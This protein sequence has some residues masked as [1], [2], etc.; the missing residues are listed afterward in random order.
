MKW[1]GVSLLILIGIGGLIMLSMMEP[2][3]CAERPGGVRIPLPS[4]EKGGTMTLE[5]AIAARRSHREFSSNPLSLEVLSRLLWSMQ[6]IT[7][8]SGKRAA[9]SAGA[10]YPIRIYTVVGERT[11]GNL[12]AG[13]YLYIPNGHLLERQ[14]EGDRRRM[15]ATASLEQ[16]WMAPAPVIFVLVAN[17]ERT[18]NRYGERGIRYVWM[19]AGHIGQNLHLQTEALQLGTCMV[20]AFDDNAISRIL[21]LPAQNEPLYIL[22]VG[23]PRK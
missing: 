16:M 11:C 8:S 9:P 21:K 15:I 19:E 20:G 12:S 23:E 18:T 10:T 3:S 13:V 14:G 4:P 22:P 7:D 17:Y 6:G 5:D 2:S 1:L